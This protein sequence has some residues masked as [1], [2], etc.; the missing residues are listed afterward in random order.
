VARTGDAIRR[1][2]EQQM[3]AVDAAATVEAI[4]NGHHSVVSFLLNPAGQRDLPPFELMQFVDSMM[5][6]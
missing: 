3:Q 5:L 6:L 2:F 4:K 1:N